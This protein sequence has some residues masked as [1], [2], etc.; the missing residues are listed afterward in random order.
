MKY[1]YK[2]RTV[3]S[4]LFK[5]VTECCLIFQ[6]INQLT[7]VNSNRMTVQDGP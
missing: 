5:L 1:Q 2:H 4:G 7:N 6:I 3:Q